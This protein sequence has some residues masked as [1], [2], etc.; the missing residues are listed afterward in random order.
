MSERIWILNLHEIDSIRFCADAALN[1]AVRA[2]YRAYCISG[3]STLTFSF[4]ADDGDFVS[5]RPYSKAA[6][7][8][9]ARGFE[10]RLAFIVFTV[11]EA[12]R[13]WLAEI[14]LHS[15]HHRRAIIKRRMSFQQMIDA[16]K[17][18]HESMRR[19]A[20]RLRDRAIPRDDIGAPTVLELDGEFV[21][22]RWVWLKSDDARDAE[23]N[24]MGNCVGGGYYDGLAPNAGVFSLR[25][26]DGE[27]H[28]TAELDGL[29]VE[30][31]EC[32]GGANV[33]EKFRPLVD[34]MAAV[35]GVR[36]TI[37]ND[38]TIIVS[39]GV[40]T[41][42]SVAAGDPT[43]YYVADGVLHRDGGPALIRPLFVEYYERGK[44]VRSINGVASNGA[45]H[46]YKARVIESP[47]NFSVLGIYDNYYVVGSKFRI[48]TRVDIDGNPISVGHAWPASASLNVG[49][50]IVIDANTYAVRRVHTAVNAPE[51]E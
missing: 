28:V 39:D 31:A 8:A 48:E 4:V 47:L 7:E 10:P 26:P 21:G 9:R 2:A 42:D 15:P 32:R 49:D 46:Y 34:R 29:N 44:S 41:I 45:P 37:H 51:P 1:D 5:T 22:W 25:D 6:A 43:T 33:S 11:A 16:A 27:P 40:H 30:Q 19:A 17:R 3:A 18:W 50:Q 35:I 36:L 23:G 14:R 13:D 24:A 12:I 20:E 38:P